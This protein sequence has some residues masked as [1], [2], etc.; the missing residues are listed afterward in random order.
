MFIVISVIRVC[1]IL[2]APNG[3]FRVVK[4]CG[5]MLT[6]CMPYLCGYAL[7]ETCNNMGLHYFLYYCIIYSIPR[8]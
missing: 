6:R 5:S 3:L 8:S 1:Y 4:L 7:E 2:L